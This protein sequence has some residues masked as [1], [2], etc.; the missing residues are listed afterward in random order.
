MRH[1]LVAKV[2]DHRTGGFEKD[3]EGKMP[4]GLLGHVDL[5]GV[6]GGREWFSVVL[7]PRGDGGVDLI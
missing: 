2:L 1:E 3:N 7:I 4:E 5:L 6:S